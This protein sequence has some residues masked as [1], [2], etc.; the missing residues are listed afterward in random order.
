MVNLNES[1]HLGIFETNHLSVTKECL[2]QERALTHIL[3]PKLFEHGY[4]GV[5]PLSNIYDRGCLS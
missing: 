2:P 4:V 1:H 5:V 3:G